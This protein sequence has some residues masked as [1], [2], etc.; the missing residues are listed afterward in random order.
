LR[1]TRLRRVD[2]SEPGIRRR[3]RGRGFEY[4]DE[5]ANRIDS[6]EALRRIRELGSRRPGSTS[7]SANTR[8]GARVFDRYLSGWMIAG[9]LD[10]RDDAFGP[11]SESRRQIIERAVIDLISEKRSPDLAK[12]G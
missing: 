4:I 11:E 6:P 10:Q 12:V 5:D 1:V 9:A 2:C 7:G 8:R 3:R